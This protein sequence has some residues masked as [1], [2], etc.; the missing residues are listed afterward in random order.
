MSSVPF[1]SHFLSPFS[2]PLAAI[3]LFFLN[4]NAHIRT[5]RDCL[6]TPRVKKS[7]LAVAHFVLSQLVRA[8]MQA[9]VLRS[10]DMV[11]L[12]STIRF[13]CLPA[14]VWYSS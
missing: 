12:A 5:S 10:G 14:D 7:F 6:L 8:P 2:R 11:W 4:P 13:S 3:H 9:S 1:L